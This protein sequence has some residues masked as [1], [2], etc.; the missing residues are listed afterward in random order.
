MT[1]SLCLRSRK[2]VRSRLRLLVAREHT[3]THRVNVKGEQV[4]AGT[5]FQTLHAA[6]FSATGLLP[7]CRET[8]SQVGL[9][10]GLGKA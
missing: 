4:T 8:E 2:Q 6:G 3:D 7:V 1:G 9:E 5:V 10:A